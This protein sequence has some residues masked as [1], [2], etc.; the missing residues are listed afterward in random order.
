ML[1]RSKDV[2]PISDGRRYDLDQ[3]WGI[4]KATGLASTYAVPFLAAKPDVVRAR[5]VGD[6]CVDYPLSAPA[7]A[8]TAPSNAASGPVAHGSGA[9]TRCDHGFTIP[10]PP[11]ALAMIFSTLQFFLWVSVAANLPVIARRRP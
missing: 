10:V 9:T 3:D 5:L 1:F 11:H 6:T 4:V 7:R 2:R 8:A